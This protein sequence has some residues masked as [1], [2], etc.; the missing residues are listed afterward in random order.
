[1]KGGRQPTQEIGNSYNQ[2]QLKILFGRHE[3]TLVHMQDLAVEQF[4]E[5]CPYK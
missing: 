2:F 5:G 1:M 4:V 3:E